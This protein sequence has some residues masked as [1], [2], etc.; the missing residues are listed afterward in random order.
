MVGD[1]RSPDPVGAVLRPARPRHVA[2]PDPVGGDPVGIHLDQ[3][4]EV[5]VRDR[6]VVALEEVVDDRLPVGAEGVG[7]AVREGERGEVR[8]VPHHLPDEAASRLLGE[9]RRLAVEVHEDEVAEHLHLDGGE[10]DRGGVEV[11]DALGVPGPAKAPVEG[12][13]PGVVGAGD[14]PRP[15]RAREQLVPAVLADVVE[16]AKRPVRAPDRHD[17]PILDPRRHVAPRLAELLL[18][19]EELPAS[20]EDLGPLG[21]EERGVDVAV[22]PNRRRPGGDRVVALPGTRELLPRQPLRHEPS[23]PGR[24]TISRLQSDPDPTPP[25]SVPSR[26]AP[27]SPC[28]GGSSPARR[29]PARAAAVR[30]GPGQHFARRTTWPHAAQAVHAGNPANRRAFLR[31]PRSTRH[32][33]R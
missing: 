6:A 33:P 19:A 31:P 16:G 3:A 32:P 11:L 10:G 17:A 12:V 27:I 1:A 24:A 29:S 30:R 9:R 25:R 21:L 5:P 26:A 15:A 8:G 4:H 28:R 20:P 2:R 23:P 22:R 14:L 13:G 7:E 18:V